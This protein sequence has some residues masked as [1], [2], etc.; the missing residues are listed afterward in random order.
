[1]KRLLLLGLALLVSAA[2][3]A[4]IVTSSAALDPETV[5]TDLSEPEGSGT[6]LISVS[7]DYSDGTDSTMYFVGN[8]PEAAFKAAGVSVPQITNMT[9]I[10][11]EDYIRRLLVH[12]KDRFPKVSLWVSVSATEKL[13]KIYSKIILW[14]RYAAW[15]RACQP[16]IHN[17]WSVS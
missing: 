17:Q 16:C 9:N 14:Q 15:L 13:F 11:N 1:M 3:N 12:F 5:I 2:L 8:S 10:T 4:Q 7:I 6:M